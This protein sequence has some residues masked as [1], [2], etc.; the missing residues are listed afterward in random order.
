MC[1]LLLRIS[2]QMK[3]LKYQAH[4]KNTILIIHF[5]HIK[6][7]DNTLKHVHTELLKVEK[8]AGIQVKT[9]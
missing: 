5:N 9:F 1:D 8:I 2:A 7:H 4:T 6:K 3:H